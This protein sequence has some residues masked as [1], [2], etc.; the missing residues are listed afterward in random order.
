MNKKLYVSKKV[1]GLGGR[2]DYYLTESRYDDIKNGISTFVYGVEIQKVTVD[3]YN[4]EYIQKR[5]IADI[6]VNRDRVVEFISLLAENEAM[7][8]SLY[9]I[10][11]DFLTDGFF[12]RNEKE[13]ISA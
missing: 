4:V 5:E 13:K 2:L 10:T 7:P 6:S 9:D 12:E 3:E 1:K 11:E 8:V